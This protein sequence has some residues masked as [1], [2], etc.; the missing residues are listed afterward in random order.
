MPKLR[1]GKGQA[2][3]EL[4]LVLPIF[5]TLVFGI[6]DFSAYMFVSVSVSHGTRTAVRRAA[7]NNKTLSE[8]KG[9]VV[10]SMP[11]VNITSSNVR[12][13]TNPGDAS[14]PN[15]PP[16]VQV[17]TRILHKFICSALV[18]ID[19]IMVKSVI[20]CAVV[21]TPQTPT[22]QFTQCA[23]NEHTGGVWNL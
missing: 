8:I 7:M 15:S 21:T 4:A 13:T 3:V 12:V 5:L 6:I 17:E 11:G 2:M 16:T 10:S 18:P 20:R 22:I 19:S 9:L 23:G 1:K 14:R